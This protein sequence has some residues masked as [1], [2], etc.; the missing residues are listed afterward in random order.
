MRLT[1]GP[2]G[3][4]RQPWVREGGELTGDD[5]GHGE[6]GRGYGWTQRR[7]AVR[8]EVVDVTGVAWLAGDEVSRRR[9]FGRR[10]LRPF[11]AAKE[12]GKKGEMVRGAWGIQTE[13]EEE[14]GR[15]VPW[16][17]R[18]PEAAELELDLDLGLVWRGVSGVGGDLGE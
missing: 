3:R 1:D 6:V 15:P 16:D 17:R 12:A 11:P 2:H 7:V 5:V 4:R 9:G 14:Q 8:L 13:A 10:R 18:R